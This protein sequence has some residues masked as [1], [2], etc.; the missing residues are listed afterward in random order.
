MAAIDTNVD[1][2]SAFHG[3]SLISKE[4]VSDLLPLSTFV[5]GIREICEIYVG[6]KHA[7]EFTDY[8]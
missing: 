5:V 4:N 2:T 7:R 3:P 8:C 6:E 1:L